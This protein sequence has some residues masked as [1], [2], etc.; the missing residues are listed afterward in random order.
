MI[1]NTSP[2]SNSISTGAERPKAKA[3]GGRAALCV[4]A[5]WLGEEQ[6]P[7]VNIEV[8]PRT[9]DGVAWSR[10]IVVQAS[11]SELVLLAGFSLGLLPALHLKRPGKGIELT[12][13]AGN[14]FVKATAGQGACYVMPVTPG[15]SF[16]VGS[17]VLTQL[18]ANAPGLAPELVLAQIRSACALVTH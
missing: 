17:V 12:R 9:Q 15:D 1:R 16:Y 11:L 4:E 14:L 3:Y 18:S 2:V 6:S 13:Q 8:A 7:T 5:S 10:K